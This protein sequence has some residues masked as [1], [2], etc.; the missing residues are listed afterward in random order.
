MNIIMGVMVEKVLEAARF[1]EEKIAKQK[2]ERQKL[3]LQLLGEI[4]E[5]ADEDGSG[6]V[7]LSEFLEITNRNDVQALFEELELSVSRQRLA[8]RLF[9][10][11][12]GQMT[13]AIDIQEFLAAALRLK[14][15][16]KMQTSDMTMLL[17]DVRHTNR[18]VERVE[19]SLADVNQTMK[20][21][22]NELKSARNEI[23]I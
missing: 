20:E 16:G 18:R 14:R 2:E 11:L 13:G 12:D 19:R 3:E 17:M 21:L 10:V 15:E 5:Q 8:M 4:F 1:N 23:A 6:K 7:S 9:E 22:K